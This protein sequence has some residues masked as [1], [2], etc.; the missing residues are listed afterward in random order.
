MYRHTL[1]R[2][3]VRVPHAG[4]ERSFV[5]MSF[6]MSLACDLMPKLNKT[7]HSHA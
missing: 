5:T 1:R 6:H 2:N 3:Q 7:S 4:K